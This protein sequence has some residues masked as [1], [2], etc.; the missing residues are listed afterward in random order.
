MTN[1]DDFD[2]SL[3]AFLADGPNTA[4]EAPVIAAMAHARTT[5]RR[6]DPLR[7]FRADPMARRRG[8]VGGR[9]G[10]VF[11]AL[12]LGVASIGVAVVGSRQPG[13]TI[14]PVP[15]ANDVS[16]QTPGPSGIASPIPTSPPPFQADVTMLVFSGQP[17]PVRVSDV[18]GELVEAVSLQP[19]DGAS[20]DGIDVRVDPTDLRALIVTWIGTPCERGG[21][22]HVDEL[23]HTLTILRD[24]CEGDPFPLDRIVRLRFTQFVEPADWSASIDDGP[25]PSAAV[26]SR[27]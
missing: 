5:P 24:P 7:A 20:V 26:S 23:A 3:G 8:N 18:T 17:F 4:P 10:L 14:I 16:T 11:A 27:P 1:L 25:V 2:R 9:A 13:N 6:P 15:S 19:G 12:A 22:V 21:S